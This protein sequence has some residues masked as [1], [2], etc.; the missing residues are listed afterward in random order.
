MYMYNINA[1]VYKHNK[2]QRQIFLHINGRFATVCRQF[3]YNFA[4]VSICV[5]V[6]I[7]IVFCFGGRVRSASNGCALCGSCSVLPLV[8]LFVW[9]VSRCFFAVFG[10]RWCVWSCLGFSW[11]F[12]CLLRAWCVFAFCF[13]CCVWLSRARLGSFSACSRLG[14]VLDR[15][16][17]KSLENRL[18]NGLLCFRPVRCVASS[19]KRK[20]KRQAVKPADF[21]ILLD[22][23]FLKIA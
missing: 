23:Y 5:Y 6:Y 17:I 9:C 10:V 16:K 20:E 19:E 18:Q 15:A 12:S 8:A 14:G 21:F 11:L 4:T 1:T 22:I 2:I 3:H 13:S 7:I